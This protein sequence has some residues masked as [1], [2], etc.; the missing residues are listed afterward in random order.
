MRRWKACQHHSRWSLL[1]ELQSEYQIWNAII[2]II[3][4]KCIRIH[5]HQ[6]VC[7][8]YEEQKR[9]FWQSLLKRLIRWNRGIKSLPRMLFV[10]SLHRWVMGAIDLWF[11]WIVHERGVYINQSCSKKIRYSWIRFLSQI[12]LRCNLKVPWGDFSSLLLFITYYLC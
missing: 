5:T 6:I 9:D 11:F 10:K 12:K 2:N 1:N 4:I 7:A 3:H 8:A